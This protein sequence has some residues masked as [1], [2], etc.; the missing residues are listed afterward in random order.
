MVKKKTVICGGPKKVSEHPL[1]RGSYVINKVQTIRGKTLY[2]G[3]VHRVEGIR[4]PIE[5]YNIH[6]VKDYYKLICLA[7][8]ESPYCGKKIYKHFWL[9]P[10][11]Y[12]IMYD[13]EY[14]IG[15]KWV[16]DKNI[17]SYGIQLP[18]TE[19]VK[20]LR[21]SFLKGQT[22]FSQ[23]EFKDN[24][25]IENLKLNN[26]IKVGK[27]YYKPYSKIYGYL[28]KESGLLLF[29]MKAISCED[30]LIYNTCND[31]TTICLIRSM[32][33]KASNKVSVEVFNKF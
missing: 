20:Y 11:K 3:C 31:S 32:G 12:S 29:I 23:E 21:T 27:S 7:D 13:I 1:L 9:G 19:G 10:V 22:T 5:S 33:L 25:C 30:G 15:L 24:I 26:Y 8:E 4:C 18:Y 16:R 6:D 2:Y 28:K 17:N 14:N